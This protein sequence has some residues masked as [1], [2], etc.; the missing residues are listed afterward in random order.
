MQDRLS[1][2]EL[3]VQQQEDELTVMRAALADVLRRLA[4]SEESKKQQNTKGIFL[5]FRCHCFIVGDNRDNEDKLCFFNTRLIW[6]LSVEFKK[7]E[8]LCCLLSSE[9]N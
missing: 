1:S 4:Q 2:L 7:T 5:F 6:T 3:R 8:L 9:N